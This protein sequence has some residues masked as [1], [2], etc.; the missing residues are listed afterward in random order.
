VHSA[1]TLI[2]LEADEFVL[3]ERFNS[4]FHNGSVGVGGKTSDWLAQSRFTAGY[5]E[6]VMRES[7]ADFLTDEEIDALISGRDFWFDADTFVERWTKREEIR[8]ERFAQE[9]AAAQEALGEYL[10]ALDEEDDGEDEPT[11]H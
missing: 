2:L 11:V 3:S 5:M 8:A 1:G 6:R 4:L 9:Q 10:E 7:Y